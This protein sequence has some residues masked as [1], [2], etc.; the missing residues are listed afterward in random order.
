MPADPT[1]LDPFGDEE[2]LSA[3]LIYVPI[4]AD[5]ATVGILSIQSYAEDAV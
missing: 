4:R 2:R 5:E 3:S 1:E